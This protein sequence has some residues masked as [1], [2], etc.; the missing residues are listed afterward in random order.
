MAQNSK[1]WGV[2]NIWQLWHLKRCVEYPRAHLWTNS[3][4]NQ[5]MPST[6]QAV[7]N[8]CKKR[9]FVFYALLDPLSVSHPPKRV[10]PYSLGICLPTTP[11]HFEALSLLQW[12]KQG[13]HTLIKTKFPVFTLCSCHFPC[14]FLLIKN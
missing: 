13:C 5:W 9:H 8:V 11:R 6:L 14:V 12:E 3:W 2:K 7:T 4:S 1:I 10:P